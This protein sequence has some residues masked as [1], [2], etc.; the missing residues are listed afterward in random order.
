MLQYLQ[1]GLEEREIHSFDAKEHRIMCFPHIVNIAVQH[2]L[3]HMSSAVAPESQDDPEVSDEEEDH[4]EDEDEDEDRIK[5]QSFEEA[6]AR[7]PIKRLRDIV[8]AIRSSGQRKDAFRKWIETG[9]A[10]GFF[11]NK[12]K[13]VEVV[14]KQLLR[15]VRTRWD[16]TYMMIRR[17]ID[18]RLVCI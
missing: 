18:M 14:E 9:N 13:T 8:V 7:D 5:R 2:V 6:C 11:V 1:K 12:G 3:S 16:S 10:N 15:D 4:D 17:C